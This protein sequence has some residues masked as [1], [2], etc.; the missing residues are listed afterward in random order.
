MPGPDDGHSLRRLYLGANHDSSGGDAFGGAIFNTGTLNV[1]GSTFSG[2]WATGGE[3]AE[4][5]GNA[6][7]GAIYNAQGG[8]LTA[9]DD[10]FASNYALG[11]QGDSGYNGVNVS[12]GGQ[13]YGGA[14]DNAGIA[15]IS[16][17]T[18]A[19]G[20][21]APGAGTNGQLGTTSDGAGIYNEAGATL[22]LVDTIV[23]KNTGGNDILNLGSITGSN[24]LVMTSS[25]VPAAVISVTA[26]PELGTLQLN[27]GTTPT[28]ALLSGSP[29][30]NAG[31]SRSSTAPTLPGLVHQWSGEGNANDSAGTSNGT[32]SST[33]VSYATGIVGQAFQFNGSGGYVTLPT[34][35]DIT[36]TGPLLHL[37]LDQDLQQWRDHPATR[38]QYQQ[39][40]VPARRPGRQDLLADYGNS[41]TTSRSLRPGPSPMA[42]GTTS[43][44]SARPTAAVRSS[45]TASSTA[46]RPAPTFP[47]VAGSASTSARTS[48]TSTT[49]PRATAPRSLPA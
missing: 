26:D 47:W 14:I 27:G 2:N 28:L 3:G 21:D 20:N 16:S 39:R 1:T 49:N 7:G 29:A 43:S 12:Y 32:L 9:A 33:G 6:H 42:S 48:E 37:R 17:T 38:S 23:A 25:N 30:L 36:G 22:A 18:I 31:T 13:A 34:S 35:A 4:F 41:N 46:L 10:T 45:S 11:G 8:V 40:R 44:P 24:N 5:G 19:D 15:L